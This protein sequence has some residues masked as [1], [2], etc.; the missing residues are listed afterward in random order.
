M[1]SR[2][3]LDTIVLKKVRKSVIPIAF[4]E[5]VASQELS[6]RSMM[7]ILQAKFMPSPELQ[8][9]HSDDT[10]NSKGKR[11]LKKNMTTATFIKSN[12]SP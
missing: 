8:K 6:T 3:I 2:K 12:K 11:A 7:I 4:V 5:R 9:W 10:T 1:R